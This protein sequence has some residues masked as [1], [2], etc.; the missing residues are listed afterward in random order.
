[1]TEAEALSN[2]PKALGY[3]ENVVDATLEA[4]EVYL[5]DTSAD[6]TKRLARE[7]RNLRLARQE[8]ARIADGTG[9][10]A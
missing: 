6:A 8:S 10:D 3:L 1:M 4:W 2:Y 7:M 9:K 5:T